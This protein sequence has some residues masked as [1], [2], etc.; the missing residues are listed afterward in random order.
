MNDR[1]NHPLPEYRHNLNSESPEVV[2]FILEK[3]AE[4]TVDPIDLSI[5]FR[6]RTGFS[7]D[8]H[9]FGYALDHLRQSGKVEFVGRTRGGLS[10]YRLIVPSKEERI[11][12]LEKELASLDHYFS[13]TAGQP[14]YRTDREAW[15]KI[16]RAREIDRELAELRKE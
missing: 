11:A 14:I 8:W 15:S 3:A 1:M 7:V 6:Q 13:M 12:A 4:R 9:E 5:A 2:D 10:M 16:D